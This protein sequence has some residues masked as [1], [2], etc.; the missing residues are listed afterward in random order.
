MRILAIDMG[1]SN[2]VCCLFDAQR[3]KKAYQSLPTEAGRYEQALEKH[4]ADLVVIEAGPLAG[5]VKDL[6]DRL[7]QRLLVLN[8][9]D[10]PWQWSNVKTK[11]DRKDALKLARIAALGDQ[12]GVHVPAHAVRQWRQ[13]IYYRQTLVSE[14]V[15]IKNRLRALLLQEQRQLPAGSK[16]WRGQEYEQLKELAQDLNDCGGDELWRGIVKLELQRLDQLLEQLEGVESKLNALAR[17]DQRV[18]QL[19][20]APGVGPR[21]AELVA[22]MIDDPSRFTRGRQVASYGGFTPKKFQS[23]KTN[24]DGHISRAG[25]GLL[26]KLLVQAAWSGKRT[27]RPMQEIYQRVRRGSPKRSK[28]AIVAVARHLLIWLWAMLRDGTQW[29]EHDRAAAR[30]TS[31][32][33]A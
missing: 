11:T 23:G 16:A 27:S 12:K 5:W 29:Q 21:T 3:G 1:W 18:E 24:R 2:S 6:C 8:T 28:Q 10:E 31:L 13:L 22:A 15:S 19:Q 4:K 7:G 14:R 20:T 32:S 30:A 25:N 26:R 33:A 17:E 9:N